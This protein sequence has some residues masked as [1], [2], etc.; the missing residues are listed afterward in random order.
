MWAASSISRLLYTV[1]PV[2]ATALVVAEAI[3]MAV[4]LGASLGPAMRAMRA[5]PVDLL[6]AT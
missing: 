5:D 4:S 3:L 2:D 6:R 1:S